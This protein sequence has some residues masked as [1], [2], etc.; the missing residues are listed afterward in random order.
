MRA[1][2]KKGQRENPSGPVRIAPQVRAP[3]ARA[4]RHQVREFPWV[5]RREPL[6]RAGSVAPVGQLIGSAGAWVVPRQ[7]GPHLLPGPVPA[8]PIPRLDERA[9]YPA[10]LLMG[11]LEPAGGLNCPHLS[12]NTT[13]AEG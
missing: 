5:D 4:S 12:P 11:A 7:A 6:T 8:R 9:N 2:T 10:A 13:G 3:P 1:A